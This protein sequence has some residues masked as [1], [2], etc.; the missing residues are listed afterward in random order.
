MSAHTRAL[1]LMEAGRLTVGV[2]VAAVERGWLTA[3][4]VSPAARTAL[5]NAATIR[6][7]AN[8]ALINNRSFLALAS[9]TNAQTLNQVKALTRQNQGLIRLALQLLDGTE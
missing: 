9:P 8:T 5:A 2:Q 3:E 6:A 1:A 7:Q 4:Q